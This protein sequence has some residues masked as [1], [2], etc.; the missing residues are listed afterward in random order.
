MKRPVARAGALSVTSA[1]CLAFSPYLAAQTAPA[2]PAASTDTPAAEEETIMLSPFTVEASEDKGS[3]RA[4]STLAGTRVRTDLNDIPSSI[5]VVTA[6]FLQDTG[7]KKQEDLLVYTT[8]TEVG[9]MR[10]NFS[11]VGGASTY[12]ESSNLLRPNENT[13]VRGLASADNTRDYFLS[14]IPWDGYN[15][16]RVDL[17]RGPNSILFGVGSPAGIINTSL[18]GAT[19]KNAN[20]FENRIDRWGSFRNSL[21]LNYVILKNELSIRFAAL[22][23]DTKYQ[24]DPAFNDDR[25]YYGAL[26]YEPKLFK[27]EGARTTIRAN[28]EQGE[29][30]ANR[31]RSLPPIDAITPWFTHMGK[32]TLNPN[33]TWNQ[34]GNNP[35]YGG[36]YP[37]F[38]E[39]FMGRLM[40]SNIAYYHNG[41]S[42]GP[43][44]VQTPNVGAAGGRNS[45]GNI[46]G[47]IGGF[48]FSR[49]W[50]IAT[51]NNYARAA[52][53]G[54]KYYSNV[55]LKDPAIYDFY[56]NLIDG[57]NK[58]EWQDWK[59]SNVAVSQTFFN[60]RLGF[61]FVYDWQ[62][63]EDGQ[64]SFLDGDQYQISVDINT[65]LMDGTLNPN[66]GR[67]YVGNSGQYG[68]RQNYIDRD[69]KR[70]TTFA[71]LR[72]DDYMDKGWLSKLIGRH[73]ITGL[74]SE[75]EKRNDSRGFA[76]WASA[77][78]FTD[79][80]GFTG[81]IIN[82]PR[83]VDWIAYLSGDMRA[84][85][86]A[87][88]NGI[89]RITGIINPTGY[90]N[91]RYFDSRWNA[92]G[93][94]FNDPYTAISHDANG[95][96]VTDTNSTQSENPA[97]Y[98]GWRNSN[99]RVLNAEKGDI[100]SLYSS[101][102]K[103]H[104]RIKSKGVTWQGY[105]WDGTVVPVFGWRRD[106]VIDARTQAPKGA[107]NVSLMDY[108]VDQSQAQ[109]AAGESKSWGFTIHTPRQFRDKL[110]GNT[111]MSVFFNRSENFKADAPRGDIFGNKIANPR[112]NTKDYGVVL[113]T[114]DDKL[115]LKATWYET[116][117]KD[118]T[119]QA[120]S[121]GFSGNLYYVW[122]LPYWGA[123]H[124]LAALD[125]IATPQLRQGNWG[126]PWNG[127][128]VDGSNNPDP[129]RIRA[130]VEDFF[131]S[132]P[133]N[134]GFVDEYGL[135]MNVAAMRAATTDAQRYASIPTYGLNGS[136][137]YDPVS[138]NGASGLGLQPL[139]AGNLRSFG[140]GPQA[141][142]DTLSKG[143][144]FELVAQP[145][146]NWNITA[147]VSKTKAT[148]SAI[149]PAIDTWIKTYSQYLAGDAGLIRLWGGD[150]LRTVWA[151]N[152]VAPYTVLKNQIGTSA[153]EVPEWRFN[154][155]TNYNFSRGIIKGSN[156]GLA[157]RW[158][159]SRI[160]G[161]QLERVNNVLTG[162]LD[163]K[164]PWY[165]PTEDH[166]DLWVGYG[167]QLSRKVG[168]RI[169]LNLRNVGEKAHL[170][171]V[172]MQ[173]D[174]S[175][176]LSRIAEGQ[177]W[178]L[179]NTFN[180]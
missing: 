103:A 147:N 46:D 165:G 145:T 152:V 39:A 5:S 89:S 129:V 108:A 162:E 17:Q 77:P 105:L 48:E 97:N 35:L 171:P 62:R 73:V 155:V 160:L 99:F 111:H 79:A 177:V 66:V 136:G 158:E 115:Q 56:N 33:T 150:P 25:R 132:F 8:N 23:D 102:Q 120:D 29:V 130:I 128:A 36:Q 11:G 90:A 156:V 144:E 50:G 166:I 58:R 149:S 70:F 40:S 153:P 121:A 71:D 9:G 163:I 109:T 167:R 72:A 78:E 81:D 119:L 91:V 125:G 6:Q 101:G 54:G 32:L 87:A 146:K 19:F 49:P 137:V 107:N 134:Q 161:Y 61:E 7:S 154:A 98:V 14:E 59:A 38:R 3:Y 75:D 140:S 68:N 15:V 127:I 133:L 80:T 53:V 34:W 64:L 157:Y 178:Q 4:T 88:G 123:T 100:E 174:G 170:V 168:W 175:V 69:S 122:A 169:Q 16:D 47:T 180:F 63:Y 141:S 113:S 45:S 20:K 176:A 110:P 74:L 96:I 1:L 139:Y 26:R 2:A 21:D 93:V 51:Y 31:P 86:G 131:R 124:A 164:K 60:D 179:T 85:P 151:N 13:R 172:N 24:Q 82:G 114:L 159:D 143:M 22:D 112:G 94:A 76:R 41:N 18:N 135:G 84:R 67:A 83:Q 92:P 148:R 95:N 12:N 55:S 44:Y 138:G 126:W 65:H 52:L 142:V 57:D 37:W 173:P 43:L 106:E 104:N 27:M 28:Y 42:S 116:S 118:A 30:R 10:G 117:V